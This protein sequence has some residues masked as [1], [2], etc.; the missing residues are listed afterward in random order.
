MLVINSIKQT[1]RSQLIVDSFNRYR[2]SN[3]TVGTAHRVNNHNTFVGSQ[4]E[5]DEAEET[6]IISGTRRRSN[7]NN[8]HLGARQ[9]SLS[10]VREREKAT[11]KA[12]SYSHSIFDS[13]CNRI[14]SFSTDYCNACMFDFSWLIMRWS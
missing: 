2:K 8:M 11:L 10:R 12:G 6:G 7:T 5:N 3:R 9:P 14:I 4:M 13:N 1:K